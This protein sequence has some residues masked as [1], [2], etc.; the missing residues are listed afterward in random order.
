MNDILSEYLRRLISVNNV[1]VPKIAYVSPDPK[2]K[3]YYFKIRVKI[4]NRGI[5]PRGVK[6]RVK[7]VDAQGKPITTETKKIYTHT[8]FKGIRTINALV[9]SKQLGKDKLFVSVM[10]YPILRP[11]DGVVVFEKMYETEKYRM[12]E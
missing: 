12:P 2:T 9:R 4:W 1:I 11:N 7:D 8:R 6:V 5:I 10:V 3:T